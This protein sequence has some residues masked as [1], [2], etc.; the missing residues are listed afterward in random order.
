[1][2]ITII[3]PLVPAEFSFD[4]W[5]YIAPYILIPAGII[6]LFAHQYVKMNFEQIFKFLLMIVIFVIVA[7]VAFWFYV[8]N[9]TRFGNS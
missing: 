2:L 8:I 7:L 1:M 3:M 6:S 9:Y 5:I 4:D